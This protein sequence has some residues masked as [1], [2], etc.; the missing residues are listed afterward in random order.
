ME[1]LTRSKFRLLVL[2][3]AGVARLCQAAE[4]PLEYQVKAAF[5]LNFTKFIEWPVTAFNSPVSPVSICVFGDDPFGNTLDQ[6]VAGEMVNGRRVTVQ[7]IKRPPPPQ[8][9]Q[10]LFVGGTDLAGGT[11]KE[12]LKILPSLGPGVLT[13]GEGAPFARNAGMIGF[14]MEDRRVR[15]DINQTA[16]ER[17]GF[18]ISSKLLSV[19]RAVQK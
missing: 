13:V 1:P 16:V 3:A 12:A 6:I 10:I 4:E 8:T 11:N 2:F 14:V 7:R 17:A 18:K 9:C 19:A 5:L 15:F